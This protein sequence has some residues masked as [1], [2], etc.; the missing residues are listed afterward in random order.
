MWCVES[1]VCICKFHLIMLAVV[2]VEVGASKKG[3]GGYDGI[4]GFE[5]YRT[6]VSIL[7]LAPF[8][9]LNIILYR[10]HLTR[11]L[12]INCILTEEH[13]SNRRRSHQDI[14]KSHIQNYSRLSNCRTW[15]PSVRF[16]DYE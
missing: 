13:Q 3:G 14:S 6:V 2:L 4:Q 9:P 15:S 10:T 11:L 12:F 16:G 5:C 7:D 1:D 8:S